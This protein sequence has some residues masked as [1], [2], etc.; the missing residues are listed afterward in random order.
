M[1]KLPL[2][3][4]VCALLGLN[5]CDDFDLSR[6]LQTGIVFESQ[7]FCYNETSPNIVAKFSFPSPAMLKNSNFEQSS[8]LLFSKQFTDIEDLKSFIV[9][10]ADELDIQF[11]IVETAT[12]K[13]VDKISLNYNNKSQRFEHQLDDVVDQPWKFEVKY[14][15]PLASRIDLH[16]VVR[17]TYKEGKRDQQA[18]S[19]RVNL[20]YK[21]CKTKLQNC[22]CPE[23]VTTIIK[24]ELPKPEVPKRKL[25]PLLG[26]LSPYLDLAS[27]LRTDLVGPRGNKTQ[28]IIYPTTIMNDELGTIIRQ[29]NFYFPSCE[30]TLPSILKLNSEIY[31]GAWTTMVRSIYQ[32]INQEQQ[33]TSNYF[34][35]L[36][37]G[38][39]DVGYTCPG[40]NTRTMNNEERSVYDSPPYFFNR[41]SINDNITLFRP[42]AY[43]DP[44]HN[45]D[46]P[47]LRAAFIKERIKRSAELG[48]S[49]IAIV[50]GEVIKR[51]DP[52]S[53]NATIYILQTD[54]DLSKDPDFAIYFK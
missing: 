49:P 16:A 37:Q 11:V 46:L 20:S 31:R 50:N 24:P 44:V 8:W 35:I 28:V 47:N 13:E 41:A 29:G 23:I 38:S 40:K 53:R 10:N 1:K 51:K 33:R 3:I 26:K 7:D 27:G 17:V 52:L 34:Y 19:N 48:E 43:Q 25:T 32:S 21:A 42:Q 5:G 9:D 14:R 12:Q 18:F 6:L 36:V 45:N 2:A 54:Q 15:T 22:Q 39:A 30:F 4:I